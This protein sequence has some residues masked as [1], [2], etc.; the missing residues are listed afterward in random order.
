VQRNAAANVIY[1]LTDM[2]NVW[3]FSSQKYPE[4]ARHTSV[5]SCVLLHFFRVCMAVSILPLFLT[6]D[7]SA[8]VVVSL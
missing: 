5:V 1:I 3:D 4:N 6:G 8:E 7:V 2:L